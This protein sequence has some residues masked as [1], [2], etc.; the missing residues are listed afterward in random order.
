MVP[1]SAA[2]CL[3]ERQLYVRG[4]VSNGSIN[5]KIKNKNK[6][7][8]I[9][10]WFL[11]AEGVNQLHSGLSGLSLPS[12]MA[13]TR[14]TWC[15]VGKSTSPHWILGHFSRRVL[16]CVFSWCGRARHPSASTSLSTKDLTPPSMEHSAGSSNLHI[17][18]AYIYM[19]ARSMI[20]IWRKRSSLRRKRAAYQ[21]LCSIVDIVMAGICRLW[22]ILGVLN[23]ASCTIVI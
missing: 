8:H 23:P 15:C 13:W 16:V 21:H 4:P 20:S 12:C 2:R 19:Y 1:D 5:K 3:T 18:D 11:F 9:I 14:F 6:R 7:K 17:G 22:H 10:S